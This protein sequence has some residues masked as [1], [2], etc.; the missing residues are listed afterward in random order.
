MGGK[1]LFSASCGFDSHL[2]RMICDWRFISV[3]NAKP[4]SRVQ[5]SKR[6]PSVEHPYGYENMRYVSS[7]VSGVGI[8][9]LGAGISC[10]HGLQSAMVPHALDADFSLAYLTLALSAVIDFIVLMKVKLRFQ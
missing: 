8:F 1:F 6:S 9:C 2:P 4:A 5:T 10:W 7:L 3:S